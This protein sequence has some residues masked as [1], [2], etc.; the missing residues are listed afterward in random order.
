MNAHV[1]RQHYGNKYVE[2]VREYNVW[3]KIANFV[4]VGPYDPP[5]WDNGRLY[6]RSDY[7]EKARKWPS[8]PEQGFWGAWIIDPSHDNY[9]FVTRSLLH[10][11][12]SQRSETVGAFFS[13]LVDAGKYIILQVGDSVRYQVGLETL[14]VKWDE[15]GLDS[16]IFV[17]PAPQEAV[18]ALQEAFPEL[19]ASSAEKYLKRYTAINAATSY[20]YALPSDQPRM[21][22]LLLSLKELTEALLEGMPESITSQVKLWRE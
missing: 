13:T 14:F 16:R 8:W 1:D 11:R 17:E 5:D 10:E 9:Y 7:S 20:G 18:A 19:P 2:I 3:R 4:G 12:E 15:K 21:E 22:L 6:F